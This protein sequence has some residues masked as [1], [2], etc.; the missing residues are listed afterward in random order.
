MVIMNGNWWYKYNNDLA[1]VEIGSSNTNFVH[2]IPE[3]FH[4]I[5]I[6][7]RIQYT[8]EASKPY[9]SKDL[10]IGAGTKDERHNRIYTDSYYFDENNR[11]T[12]AIQYDLATRTLSVPDNW[13][14]AYC[15][16]VE[17]TPNK[18]I[19]VWCRKFK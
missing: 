14:N 7:F 3:E 6:S 12:W 18:I 5:W 16:G 1:W 13:I 17:F 11:V 2:I 15:N 10:Y 8:P 4:E 19:S 9:I